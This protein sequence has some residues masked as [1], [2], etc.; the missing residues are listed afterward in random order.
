MK[1]DTSDS[2]FA[3]AMVIIGLVIFGMAFIGGIISFLQF[4]GNR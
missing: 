1:N 4:I 2:I 3:V